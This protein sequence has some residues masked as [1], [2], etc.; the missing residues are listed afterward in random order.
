M[1]LLLP[2]DPLTTV[3]LD[4]LIGWKIARGDSKAVNYLLAAKAA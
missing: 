1:Y 2:G 3:I 4:V